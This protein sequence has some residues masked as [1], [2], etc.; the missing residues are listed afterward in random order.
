M[1]TLVIPVL[2][3]SASARAEVPEHLRTFVEKQYPSLET[4][5][6]TLH[7]EPEL[8]LA[9]EKTA[10]RLAG[11]LRSAGYEVTTNVGGH[12]VVAVLKN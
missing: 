8:S 3:L 11:E 7:R 2:L 6:T 1:S 12:G 5:Y 9:E 4:F 10:E